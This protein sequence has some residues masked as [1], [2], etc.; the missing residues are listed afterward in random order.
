VGKTRL[1]Q[2]LFDERIGERTLNS[3]QAFYTD[4]SDSPDPDPKTLA[5]QL[6]AD[7]TR[8]ILIVDNC[9]PDLHRRLTQTC[10]AS[11]STVS[12]LTVEYDVRDDF[13]EETSVFRLEPASKEIMEKLIRQRFPHIGQVDAETIAEFSGGNARVAIVLANTVQKG[14]SLSGFRDEDLFERLFRQRHSEDKNLLIS[15]EACSLVY[16]FE[17]TDTNSKESELKF[18]AS[19][20]GKSAN[21]LYR[22][23]TALKDRDLIQSRDVWRALLPHAIANRLARCALESIPKDTLVQAFLTNSERLIKSFTRRLSYLHDCN[24]AID[25]VNE[26]L[27]PDGWIGKANGNL[28]SFGMEVLR[29][30]APVSPEKTL[31]MIERAAHGQDGDQFT[32]RENRNFYEFVRL[33]RHLAYDPMLFDRSVNLICHYALSE[34]PEGNNNSTRDI[35]ESLFYIYL[36][37]THAPIEARTKIIEELVD[38]EDRDKQ[39][40]GLFLLNAAL[41]TWHFH[42][43]HE[44]NF[45]ARRRDYG[46]CPENGEETV[47]W[48]ETFINICTRLALSK[49]IAQQARKL[50]ADN[51]RGLWTTGG[52][53]EILEDAARQIHTQQAWNEGW[54][55][56]R[57]IITYGR[58]KFNEEVIEKLNR[59]EKILRPNNLLERARTFALSGEHHT[60]DLE[61]D[62]DNDEN[63][64]SV[65]RRMEETTRKI[66][67]QVAQDS[68]TLSTLLPELVSTNNTRLHNFGQGLA[69]GCPSK[70]ELWH[71]LHSQLEKTL[72]E[73]RNFGVLLGFLSVC[74]E[75]DPEFYHATLDGLINDDVLGEWFPFF[76]ATAP[77]DPK[78]LERLHKALDGGRARIHTFQRLAWSRAH[79]VIGDD[80]LAGL[81]KKIISKEGGIDV[82]IEILNKRFHRPK[83]DHPQYSKSL[84]DVARD[85]LSVYPFSRERM[86]H[87][88]LD[89]SLAQIARV[90]LNGEEGKNAAFELCRRLIEAIRDNRIYSFDWEKLFNELARVQP[91]IFLDIFLGNNGIEDFYRV[92]LIKRKNPITQISDDDLLF[93]C[94]SD[95]ENRYPLIALSIQA[96]SESPE[97]DE[98]ADKASIVLS[99][100]GSTEKSVLVWKPL[101]YSMFEKAPNLGVV[102]EC[103]ADTIRQIS[104]S[105]S[106]VDI[107]QNR[108]VLFQSLYQHD[109]AEISAWARSQHSKLQEEIKR[110]REFEERLNRE[111]NE[112]FE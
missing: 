48:Y 50:L 25:I 45:G 90:C 95:P 111:R 82:A 73:K 93:W 24:A 59:L 88:N 63:A 81:L 17:G 98:L 92:K 69:D 13:P 71:V 109:N 46:Y 6:I 78:G 35:L 28:T 65:W 7:R 61:E 112:S 64:S 99:P 87:N 27:A 33:L 77:I 102:L 57:G 21:D 103:L 55:A 104:S 83:E 110:E 54:I 79:E 43:T 60:F 66:G 52:M 32:S 39:E 76:Q 68:D 107:L 1:V 30:I 101:V 94:D 91:F 85:V 18:L 5:E 67:A 108:S 31:E 23:V 75:S 74:A 11:H 51:L 37:G 16:S 86:G 3:S 89:H 53:F 10:S 44:F 14:E 20:V 22:D 100:S 84:I 72:P 40:L 29:N 97:K 4:M 58:K 38:S 9:P 49:P 19:L 2:A 41:T 47:H 26:W 8:A 56:V 106:R 15:A 36:S 96:F 80:E 12:L 62:F 34:T 105:G 70:K 42:S